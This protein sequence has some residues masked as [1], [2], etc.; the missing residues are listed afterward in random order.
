MFFFPEAMPSVS[1]VL[2][3]IKAETLRFS[4][5]P[6]PLLAPQQVSHLTGRPTSSL[7]DPALAYSSGRFFIFVS[8][9]SGPIRA[10]DSHLVGVSTTDFRRY[11]LVLDHAD[12]ASPILF[13]E[14]GKHYLCFCSGFA[15][16][17]PG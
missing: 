9:F 17:S 3:A 2:A 12:G 15:K 14:G 10:L 7:K 8:D 11:D 13:S 4:D 16:V 5:L 6:T 1:A